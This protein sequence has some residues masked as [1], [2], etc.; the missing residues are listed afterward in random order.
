MHVSI[1]LIFEQMQIINICNNCNPTAVTLKARGT[2]IHIHAL[3]SPIV[4]GQVTSWEGYTWDLRK[5]GLKDLLL[6]MDT[7]I[8]S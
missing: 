8:L 3:F 6:K 4:D 5:L 1:E 7:T 2:L